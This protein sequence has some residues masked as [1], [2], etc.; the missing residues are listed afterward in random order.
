MRMISSTIL[1]AA[2]VAVA[3]PA[4]ALTTVSPA[5]VRGDGVAPELVS[6]HSH[7]RS[8]HRHHCSGTHNGNC[9]IFRKNF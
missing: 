9:R 8:H 7:M 3:A 2:L 6:M 4:F 5:P 1:A